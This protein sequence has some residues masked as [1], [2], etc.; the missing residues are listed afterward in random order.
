MQ[1]IIIVG[2]SIAADI[3]YGFL[4]QDRRYEVVCFAVDKEYIT[5]E[6]KFGLKVENLGYISEKYL[7]DNHRIMLG[8]G[9]DNVNQTRAVLFKKV[10]EMGYQIETYIHESAVVHPNATVGEGSMVLSNSVVEPYAKIGENVLIW[11][12]CTIAHHG[13]L[14]SHC[15]VASNSI[16]SG[17]AIVK[18]FT[19]I[20]VNCTIV[21]EVV[22][23]ELNIIGA[24]SLITKNTKTKDVYLSRSSEKHRF[25]SVNYSKFFLK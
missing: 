11:S 14:G 12:N 7:T 24:G 3:V 2:N 18:D 13:E 21:N 20:G 17:Q 1:K 10:K 19:F 6:R 22:V 16:I 25:D 5:E 23:D 4:E 8:V 9:Y 15:W